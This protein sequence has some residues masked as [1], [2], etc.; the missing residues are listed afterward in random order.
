MA[1]Q[2]RWRPRVLIV[3][4]GFGGLAMALELK[5]SGFEDFL[6]L[7]SAD[8]IGGVW[9]ENTYPGAACDI[10]APYYSFSFAPNPAWPSRFSRRADIHAYLKRVAGSYGLYEHIRFAAHVTA[11]TFDEPTGRW[12]VGTA[13][14]DRYTAEVFVPAIGQLSRPALPDI[15]GLGSFTGPAF[16]SAS[17]DHTVDL[18]GKRVAVIGTG[19]SAVQLVPAVAPRVAR[20]SVFQRS[21]PWILPRP[22]VE[23]RP[24]H[25]E[26]FRRVPATRLA[27]RFGW[28][29]F[30]EILALGL[31]DIPPLRGLVAAASRAHLRRQI[32]DPDL[33]IKVTPDYDPGCKRVLFSGDYLPALTRAD[34]DVETTGITR[35]EP[36]GVRTDDGRLHTVDVIV[37]GTG[38]L[39]SDFLAPIQVSGTGDRRLAD[40]W[41]DGAHAYLG[42]SVPGFPNMFCMY[43]PNTN[44]GVGSIVHMLES[45]ARYVRQAVRHLSEHGRAYLDVRHDVAKAYD[46]TLQQRLNRSVWTLCSSWYRN[47]NGRITN[48]WPGGTATYRLATRVFHT[49]DYRVVPVSSTVGHAC[50][51]RV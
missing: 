3:G 19:A 20:L 11:A 17:W 31:V 50:R 24:W 21:A 10:P 2:D 22:E 26:L 8:D 15:A 14:G 16:H 44:L 4:S 39:A 36:G 23:Y 40:E 42:M 25:H 12:Q 37:Y 29:L 6:L 9:R 48:N 49:D 28:W 27:E 45:Q 33:R 43:G 51:P 32:P 1:Y 7:E 38:F 46:A 35:I 34:V 41:Q 30:C 13:G 18:T 5:R 47:H